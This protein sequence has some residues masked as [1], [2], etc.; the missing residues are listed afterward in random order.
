MKKGRPG[1][2]VSGNRLTGSDLENDII[3]VSGTSNRLAD[4]IANRSFTH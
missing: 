2:Q 4:L 3:V 1:V